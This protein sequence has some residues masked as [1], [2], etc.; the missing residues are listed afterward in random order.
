MSYTQLLTFV[1]I[2]QEPFFFLFALKLAETARQ[3]PPGAAS[4]R[5]F[6]RVSCYSVLELNMARAGR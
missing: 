5:G 3:P 6:C 1:S 2:L 4:M